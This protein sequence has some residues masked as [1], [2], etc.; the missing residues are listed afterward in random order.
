M[1]HRPT[2]LKLIYRLYIDFNRGDVWSRINSAMVVQSLLLCQRTTI[3]C[4]NRQSIIWNALRLRHLWT[5]QT[6]INITWSYS[7]KKIC[8]R[9][10]SHISQPLK[11]TS[12]NW[13][14]EIL[15]KFDQHT[16]K[17]VYKIYQ[18]DESWI[19]AYDT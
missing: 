8:F 18:G 16:S 15:R 6:W 5:L 17:T 19:Y 11:K 12:V 14:K 2:G 13:D 4:L 7:R 3:L 1:T 10:I 9:W